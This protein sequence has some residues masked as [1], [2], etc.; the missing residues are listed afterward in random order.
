MIINQ[1][2]LLLIVFDLLFLHNGG[3]SCLP[4]LTLCLVLHLLIIDMIIL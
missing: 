1:G 2:V 3:L 4:L